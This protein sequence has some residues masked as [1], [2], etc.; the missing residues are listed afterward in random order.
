MY[1][2]SKYFLTNR[3]SV[4]RNSIWCNGKLALDICSLASLVS[5]YTLT[6]VLFIRGQATLD[7]SVRPVRPVWPVW[8]VGPVWLVRPDWPVLL[9]GPAGPVHAGGS[10]RTSRTRPAGPDQPVWPVQTA[11]PDLSVLAR[12][13]MARWSLTSAV[14]Q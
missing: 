3:Q 8:L 9:A 13:G 1:V 10:G 2:I 5:R 12:Q 7:R 6:T 11:W 14:F 4:S